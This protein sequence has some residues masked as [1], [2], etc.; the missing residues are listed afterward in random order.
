MTTEQ[1]LLLNNLMYM[2]YD[3]SSPVITGKKTVG[4]VI[5]N[6]SSSQLQEGNFSTQQDYEKIINA[7]K[8]DDTL[9]NMEIVTT[10]VDNAD[11]GGGGLSAVFV[12]KET[13]DAVV[14]FKGT[15]GTAE[16]AD[17]FRGGNV[18]DTPCQENALAWYRDT[19]EEY[20]LENYN[21]TVSGHSKGGNKAKYI[22]ILDD[23]VDH[24]VSFDGQGVSD[25]FYD[26]YSDEIAKNQYKIENHNVD[27]DYV[28]LLLN[29]IG[30]TTYYEGYDYGEGGFLENHCANTFMNFNE[31]GSFSLNV[32]PDGQAPEMA[33]LDRFLN[34]YLRSMPENERDG[35]LKMV[36]TFIDQIFQAN[37]ETNFFNIFFQIAADPK[38]SD[39]M[40]Y[41]LAY[42]ARYEQDNPEFADQI[43]GVMDEFGLSDYTKFIDI[44]DGIINF[45][46]LGA[47][48]NTILRLFN[49][50]AGL[51]DNVFNALSTFLEKRFGIKLSKEQLR[52]LLSVLGMMDYDMRN[53]QINNDYAD[54]HIES[55]PV[56]QS[57]C[58]GRFQALIPVMNSVCANMNNIFGVLTQLNGVVENEA[59][60]ISFQTIQSYQIKRRLKSIG[61]DIDKYV[62]AAKKMHDA[63]DHALGAYEKTER[64]IMDAVSN[65]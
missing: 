65:V 22:C 42:I 30:N 50:A 4:D 14:L 41:F 24:C 38:Y 61:N 6:L 62:E 45:N 55:V 23:S 63:L 29:D 26:K 12:S 53:I 16:W 44:A 7:I 56:T 64:D 13:N 8:Q 21:V 54:R 27:Y 46:F 57:S 17:N 39:D 35:A 34:S 32:N 10:H 36:N 19:Y 18:A 49:S 60:N 2:E 40:A 58:I 20:G 48:F 25:K 51:P 5:N 59:N 43:K 9:M 31:D 28:N 52:N 15:E 47:D 37:G 3:E 11:G 1:L 33:A